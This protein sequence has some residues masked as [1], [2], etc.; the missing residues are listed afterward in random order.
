MANSTNMALALATIF[1]LSLMTVEGISRALSQAGLRTDGGKGRG[2]SRMKGRDTL[3]ISL[4]LAGR[5]GMKAAPAFVSSIID[6]ELTRGMLLQDDQLVWTPG[7][8]PAQGSVLSLMKQDLLPGVRAKSTLGEF[9]G[10]WIDGMYEAALPW[11]DEGD[12]VL[13]IRLNAQQSKFALDWAGNRLELQ[14]AAPD[15]DPNAAP[16]WESMIILNGQ[17]FQKL[18]KIVEE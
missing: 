3:N 10:N 17:L 6:M 12:A 13:Q 15:A 11:K 9:I 4:A 5:V 8:Q 1:D 18:V 2:A 7:D 16:A 14:F